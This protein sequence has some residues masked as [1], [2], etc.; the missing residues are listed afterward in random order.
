MKKTIWNG[1]SRPRYVSQKIF[2]NDLVAILK[3][4][5]LH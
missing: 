1:P 3:K 2:D 5:Q 4:K